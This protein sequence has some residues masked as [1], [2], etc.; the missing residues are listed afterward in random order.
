MEILNLLS[1][2]FPRIVKNNVFLGSFPNNHHFFSPTSPS[3][4]AGVLSYPSS[5]GTVG[6]TLLSD[7]PLPGY[8][9]IPSSHPFML[10]VFSTHQKPWFMV[11]SFVF[12]PW[13][14]YTHLGPFIGVFLFGRMGWTSPSGHR[15]R[16][17]SPC[18]RLAQAVSVSR[19][20]CHGA[21]E[22]LDLLGMLK[23]LQTLVLHQVKKC[24]SWPSEM[25][26]RK[27][28]NP[29]WTQ[30]TL[31]FRKFRPKKRCPK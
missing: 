26:T 21:Y 14:N 17:E 22:Q 13:K 23:D 3:C 9:I 5:A 8:P 16:W 27:R 30:K 2:H 31:G 4:P 6:G 18:D 1:C 15:M 25:G 24:E 28:R 19:T 12:F 7:D 10:N 11:W 20:C 29:R